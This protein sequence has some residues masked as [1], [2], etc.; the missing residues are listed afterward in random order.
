MDGA[1]PLA[2]MPRLADLVVAADPG[3]PHATPDVQWQLDGRWKEAAA[4]PAEV[5]LQ[6]QAQA[7]LW[8]VCQRCLQPAAHPIALDQ[9][10]RFVA[11]E[12]EA[13]RL[14]EE[15]GDEEDV[16]VLPRALKVSE[17]IE[18]E[19]IL[20]LPIV[21]MHEVCPQ[22]LS[23]QASSIEEVSTNIEETPTDEKPHPFAA[24]AQ[25]KTQLKK[26]S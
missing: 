5:R 25:L 23:Y 4:R 6:L 20:A 1:T 11:S 17:L 10:Y 18:D 8:L 12:E 14:D 24:L 7:K 2:Q 9:T 22:P 13:A 19:L 21:P 3:D 16:L 15:A 26:K